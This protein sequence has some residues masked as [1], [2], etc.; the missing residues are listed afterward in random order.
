MPVR[1]RAGDR[2]VLT[3]AV[4]DPAGF[5]ADNTR[6]LLLD[7]SSR[8]RVSIVAGADR[9]SGLYVA[10]A[11]QSVDGDDGFEV[12]ERP[13]AFLAGGSN[14]QPA[15]RR[16]GGA[17]LDPRPRSQV[18][19]D[20]SR[21]F[22]RN[23]GGLLVAASDDVEPAVL[24]TMMGWQGFSAAVQA[25]PAGALA[26]TD[27]RHP[28]FRPF[29]ALAANL[30]EGRFDRTWTLRAEGWDVLARFT[31]GSP[32]LIERREG[33]GRVVLFASDL[34]PPLERFSAQP[35]VRALH[36]RDR[37]SYGRIERPAA[38]LCGGRGAGG[39]PR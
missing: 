29:G 11:L 2:G 31:N 13:A 36:H 35:G 37:S 34:E 17:A 4:D 33:R 24:A 5:Q 8:T 27:V 10:R 7:P 21:A 6:L 12:E 3:A 15:T 18:A 26:P 9:E 20:A 23:G 16:G 38:R 28:I 14:Q 25:E 19:R 32:A 22:V 30:G 39:R 1:Y